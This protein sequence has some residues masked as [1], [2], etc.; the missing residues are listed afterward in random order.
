MGNWENKYLKPEGIQSKWFMEL[1]SHNQR[2]ACDF[3]NFSFYTYYTVLESIKNCQDYGSQKKKLKKFMNCVN[4]GWV[5]FGV[6]DMNDAL[7]H[8]EGG[9]WTD[10]NYKSYWYTTGKPRLYPNGSG[11]TSAYGCV[12]FVKAI[13]DELYS[14]EKIIRE[15]KSLSDQL[16]RAGNN[17]NKNWEE[18]G[19]ILSKLKDNAERAEPFLW[20]FPKIQSKVITIGSYA[21]LLGKLH[22]AATRVVK[23][24]SLGLSDFES[25]GIAAGATVLDYLPILGSL[26]GT[27]VD[28]AIDFIPQW[29]QFIQNYTRRIDYAAEGRDYSKIRL[30]N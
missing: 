28:W 13:E 8:M 3:M 10:N 4:S 24:K 15:Y 23:L 1:N 11:F 21:D 5:F 30:G 20:S 2:R 27:A 7:K 14:L 12:S 29:K 18:I 17:T 26:Y 6:D 9:T 19:D 25:Y 16:S 22:T